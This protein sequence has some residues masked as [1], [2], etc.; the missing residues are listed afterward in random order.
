MLCGKCG[1]NVG[2]DRFC[3]HCGTP[4]GPQKE[5]YKGTLRANDGEEWKYESS[6]FICTEGNPKGSRLEISTKFS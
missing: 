4:V 3:S 6:Q 1:A 2:D 5:L